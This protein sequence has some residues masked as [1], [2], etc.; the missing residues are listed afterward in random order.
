MN[1]N[2]PIGAMHLFFQINEALM[3]RFMHGKELFCDI[4]RAKTPPI[5]EENIPDEATAG[6]SNAA[7][8]SEEEVKKKIAAK[9]ILPNSFDDIERLCKDVWPGLAVIG[10]VDRGLRVG[11][12]CVHRPSGKKAVILGS[13]KSGLTAV[14]V[15]WDDSD[16]TVRSVL[17]Y[18]FDDKHIFN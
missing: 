16:S 12:K 18:D 17:N 8:A 10:G 15:Q 6:A 3:E 14:K 9:K 5:D 13:L 7:S 11:A 1:F 4:T 2:D